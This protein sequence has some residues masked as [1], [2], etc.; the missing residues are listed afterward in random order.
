MDVVRLY[1][2]HDEFIMEFLFIASIK[3]R[4]RTLEKSLERAQMRRQKRKQ[5]TIWFLALIAVS[6]SRV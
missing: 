6:S 2:A 3:Y 4:H 5:V 1:L